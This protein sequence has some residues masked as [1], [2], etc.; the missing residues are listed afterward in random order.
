MTKAN[1]PKEEMVTNNEGS[2]NRHRTIAKIVRRICM[3]VR[4]IE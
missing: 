2:F 1:K 4:F 3:R